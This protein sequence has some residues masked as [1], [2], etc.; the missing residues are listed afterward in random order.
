M[1]TINRTSKWLHKVLGLGLILFLIWM[2][3][4]GV[5]LNH[6]D[7]IAGVSVPRWLVPS[8]YH[9]HNWNRSGIISAVF[10]ASE[11]GTAYLAGNLGVYRGRH[12]RVSAQPLRDGLPDS[13]YYRKTRQLFLLQTPAG[14]TLLAATAGGLFR[15][16]LTDEAWE[17]VPLGAHR[18]DVRKI[19]RVADRLV[20]FTDSAAYVAPLGAHTL[21]FT[22]Y[23]P[24]RPSEAPRVSLVKLFFDLHDGKVWGLPG[25]LLFD[26]AG[27]VLC[28][29]SLS[30]FYTWYY[31][32]R[33]AQRRRGRRSRPGRWQG[34]LFRFLH[35]YHLKLG[36]WSAGFLLVF[37][38]TGF[39][40][41]PP[42]LMLLAGD[43]PAAWYPG[44][45]P[46]NPWADKIHN[47]L[48]D[49]EQATILIQASDGLWRGPAD[50]T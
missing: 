50:L 2:S 38:L 48:H 10:P 29:L 25:R 17:Q 33:L 27:L 40:M 46:A 23:E 5:L 12:G 42:M 45:L 43:V 49:P 6:P 19:L 26:A 4:S 34:R 37:G 22:R 44:R 14:E 18:E 30:A 9:P 15:R 7:L 21:D 31:P 35:K 36:I 24:E 8:Q 1:G 39:F 11:P 16:A 28:Y 13:D 41:R 20:V 32:R 47:A 3:L